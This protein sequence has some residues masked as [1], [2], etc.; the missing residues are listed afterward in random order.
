MTDR[1]TP[2]ETL[3]KALRILARDI[4]SGDGCCNACLLEVATRLEELVAERRWIPITEKL[5]DLGVEV[6]GWHPDDRVRSWCR[7]G[8][9]TVFGKAWE[10][11]HWRPLPSP[12]VS[13]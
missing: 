12:P 3:V 8:G 6:I 1:R 13:E 5:P 9:V 11:T 10:P 2:D 7:H 4:Q